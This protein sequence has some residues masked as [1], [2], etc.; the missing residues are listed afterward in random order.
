MQGHGGGSSAANRALDELF[1]SRGPIS[2]AR[3]AEKPVSVLYVQLGALD[4]SEGLGDTRLQVRLRYGDSGHFQEKYSQKVR[5]S[6]SAPD[7]AV[8]QPGCL[9]QLDG[10]VQNPE[11]NGQIG[12]CQDWDAERHRWNVLLYGHDGHDSIKAIQPQQLRSIGGASSAEL[13]A[14]F[15]FR[16]SSELSPYLSA[17]VL[18]L[19]SLFDSVVARATMRLPFREGFPGVTHEDLLLAGGSREAGCCL[20]GMGRRRTSLPAMGRLTV[21]AELKSFSLEELELAANG[22]HQ[23]SMDGSGR[24]A[25]ME[26]LGGN[27][28]L[29]QP[30]VL[31]RPVGGPAY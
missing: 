30:V 18:K 21:A 13:G 8:M 16:W 17:E 11:L 29:D 24:A 3:P 23:A 19:G 9:V 2:H 27:G 28:P 6:T 25:L 22:G 10:L 12:T 5:S 1:A 20:P 15:V 31:G 7:L 4:L 26:L 14:S